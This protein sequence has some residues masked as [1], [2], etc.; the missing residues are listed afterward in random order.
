[1]EESRVY[2]TAKELLE[3]LDALKTSFRGYD[4]EAVCSYIQMLIRSMEWEKK[5]EIAELVRMT[6]TL[7]RDKDA[8]RR[9]KDAL[10]QEVRDCRIRIRE[11]EESLGNISDYTLLREYPEPK[12]PTLGRQ[13]AD[14]GKRVL[15]R[16]REAGM[17][18]AGRPVT[19]RK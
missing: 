11:L 4:K 1:M 12:Q 8:L 13:C 17:R 18:R 2:K 14:M 10:A 9:E 19:T 6:D 5:K 3:E 16:C 15:A 7:Q